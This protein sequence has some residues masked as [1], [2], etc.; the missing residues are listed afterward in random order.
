LLFHDASSL[1]DE[2]YVRLAHAISAPAVAADLMSLNGERT[3][4]ADFVQRLYTDNGHDDG[5]LTLAGLRQS[6]ALLTPVGK[7]A[8]SFDWNTFELESMAPYLAASRSE[9][10]EAYNQLMEQKEANMHLPI[11]QID[12]HHLDSQMGAWKQST[13]DR[14][15]YAILVEFMPSFSAGQVACERYLG[16]RDGAEVGI[17]LELYR[18]RHGKYPVTLTELLPGLLPQIPADRI[19]G[20]P[21]KYRLIDGKPVVYSVGADRVDDGGVSPDRISQRTHSSAAAWGIDQASAPRGD[22]ILFAAKPAD[23]T[24][25]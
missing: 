24:D 20:D 10:I 4:F 23:V 8:Q 22:W 11:R 12:V 5:H 9:L 25:N 2:Q 18:R 15:R 6:L 7:P 13:V 16:E 17:A 3:F 1:N 21:V 14:I 19:T